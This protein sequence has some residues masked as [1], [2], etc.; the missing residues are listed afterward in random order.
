MLHGLAQHTITAKLQSLFPSHCHP[1][2][3]SHHHRTC[4]SASMLQ[5]LPLL[6]FAATMLHHAHIALLSAQDCWCWPRQVLAC[7]LLLLVLAASSSGVLAA[8]AA[9]C[10]HVPVRGS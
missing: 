9:D 5:A 10:A 2:N 3:N 8:A 1:K 6:V 4:R 7:W